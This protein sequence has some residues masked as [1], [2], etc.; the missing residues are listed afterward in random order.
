M[1]LGNRKRGIALA[2]GAVLVVVAVAGYEP[3]LNLLHREE[4]RQS[5]PADDGPPPV[6]LVKVGV[7]TVLVLPSVVERLGMQTVEVRSANVEDSLALSGTLGIDPTRLQEVRT[8]F[9]GEIVELGKTSE[10]DRTLQYGDP[11]KQGQTLAVMW[12]RDLGEKKSELIDSLVQ[13]DLDTK[14]LQRLERSS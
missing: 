11:V 10:G 4:A 7:D 3:A 14:T 2:A 13:F 6:Q 12:S 9:A 1:R 5:Q 8:R